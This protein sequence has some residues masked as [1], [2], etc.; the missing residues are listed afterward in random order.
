MVL[1]VY[2][3]I[4]VCVS[5][6]VVLSF[7]LFWTSDYTFRYN[8]WTHQPGSH[9]R[10]A[11]QGHTLSGVSSPPF[12]PSAVLYLAFIFYR[13]KDSTVSFPRRP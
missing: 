3:F 7:N 13:E 9:R 10:K 6:C 12:G 11:R 5:L 2:I 4:Q 1:V 8:M